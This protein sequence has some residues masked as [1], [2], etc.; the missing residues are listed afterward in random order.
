VIDK[1][2]DP[3]WPLTV[4]AGGDLYF[5]PDGGGLWISPHDEVPDRA[6]DAQ[7]A[8]YD[9]ALAIDRFENA[10][11]AKVER[12]V[13]SWAGLRSFAP[14]RLPVL[15]F[16]AADDAFYWCAGQGG[17]GIQTAPA[18]SALAAVQI[19]KRLQI[20]KGGGDIRVPPPPNVDAEAYA[21]ARFR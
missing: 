13:N 12:V 21:P 9:I 5:K 2:V 10:T 11:T 18:A 4:D 19:L 8:E 6:G 16:D 1:P 7:P 15:G 14:D 20:Q 3:Q 17:F